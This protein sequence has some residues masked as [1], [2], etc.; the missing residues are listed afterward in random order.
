MSVED[1]KRV[2]RRVLDEVANGHNLA[3]LDDLYGA[4]PAREHVRED[5]QMLHTAFPDLRFTEEDLI[6]EGELVAVRFTASGT[7]TGPLQGRPP[8]GEHVTW[9]GLVL[10]RV[11]DG[12]I[13]GEWH[14]LDPSDL[15]R[16]LG[17]PNRP[18]SQ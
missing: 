14:A 1:N 12:R 16:M 6:G 11:V 8:T 15:M 5:T 2:V 3:V 18:L 7:Q 13:V 4:A 10:S 9:H 17:I